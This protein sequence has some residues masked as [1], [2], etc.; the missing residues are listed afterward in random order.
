M[1]KALF[2]QLRDTLLMAFEKHL[3]GE[4]FMDMDQPNYFLCKYHET[5]MSEGALEIISCTKIQV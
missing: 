1:L 2:Q 5:K 4:D 3:T